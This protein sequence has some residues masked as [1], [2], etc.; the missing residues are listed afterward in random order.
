MFSNRLINLFT[1]ILIISPSI[2]FI[3]NNLSF[4]PI[5]QIINPLILSSI[6]CALVLLF[7][8]FF[9]FYRTVIFFSVAW[10]LQFY[11]LEISQIIGIK[12]NIH[13][14]PKLFLV[15]FLISL[16]LVFSIYANKKFLTLLINLNLIY[17]FLT[18][19]ISFNFKFFEKPNYD[20]VYD[21][22]YFNLK[23]YKKPDEIVNRNIYFI[24]M[25]E[26]T[27]V[28]VYKDLGFNFED[29]IKS[30][31][32]LGFQHLNKSESS[33]YSTQY[34]IGSIFNMEYYKEGIYILEKDFYPF[35]L[36]LKEKPNLLKILNYYNYKF[37]FLDNQYSKCKNNNTIRCLDN[38]NLITRII[39]D[40]SL[41]VFFEKSFLKS[42][43]YKIKFKYTN[44]KN[45]KTEVQKMIDFIDENIDLIKNKKNFFWVH[46]MNPHYPYRDKD[47][48]YLH[49]TKRYASTDE[50][51]IEST[52]CSLLVIEKLISK[53]NL[54]DK[55]AII[56]F[57][58]D[59]GYSKFNQNK[60]DTRSHKIFN[61]VKLP[62]DC[63][64]K[65]NKYSGTVS[66]INQVFGC[67]KKKNHI[68]FEN[69]IF[70]VSERNQ[71]GTIFK[72]Y[73]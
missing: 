58:A 34:T 15:I 19:L 52:K 62:D 6:L 51:F 2:I 7:F 42:V 9:N 26:M 29:K 50:N 31:E 67:Y 37:W 61:L 73:N 59:H 54:L 71:K 30:F 47:C 45:K 65:I 4:Y 49:E 18:I 70:K 5:N 57:Q 21:S 60:D 27:S 20:K 23:D 10:S 41:N 32:S 28:D 53:I 43:I 36:Y 40:E 12:E 38:Q 39:T 35:N 8:K 55:N 25:D 64:K 68:S 3:L 72:K 46:N 56:V 44:Y 63:N 33:Y 13:F 1:L 17:I 14:Y 66:T 11:F 22:K 69:K 24:L 16:S 48:N